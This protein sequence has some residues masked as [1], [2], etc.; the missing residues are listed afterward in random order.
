LKLTPTGSEHSDNSKQ[1]TADSG[2]RAAKSDATGDEMA[3]PG[4]LRD[5]LAALRALPAD[6]LDLLLAALEVDRQN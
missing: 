4:H 1:K 6:D 3:L 2:R 5:L